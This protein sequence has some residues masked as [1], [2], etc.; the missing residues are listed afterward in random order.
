MRLRAVSGVVVTALAITFGACSSSNNDPGNRVDQALK[1]A[2]VK[3]VNVDWDKNANVVH[4]K[5]KV[6]SPDDRAKAEQV[7]TDVVGTSGKVMNELTVTGMD[8]KTADNADGLIKSRLNDSI[9]ADPTLSDQ[10]IDF[11]VNNGMVTITGEVQTAA[12]KEKVGQ[13][14]KGTSGVRDVANELSVKQPKHKTKT[15]ARH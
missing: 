1:Q 13:L 11:N 10:T 5:G 15:P 2:N 3:H 7:A 8:D 6:D 9:K 12:E 4:L 14:A